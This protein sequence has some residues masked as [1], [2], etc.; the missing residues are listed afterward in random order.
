MTFTDTN[1]TYIHIALK[2]LIDIY[3][4]NATLLD[5]IF[6]SLLY[7][8]ITEFTYYTPLSTDYLQQKSPRYTEHTIALFNRTLTEH[9]VT[10]LHRTFTEHNIALLYININRT[11]L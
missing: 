6:I 1:R 11:Y 7:R 8:T 2:N 9:I 3:K 5:I 10:M 4:R